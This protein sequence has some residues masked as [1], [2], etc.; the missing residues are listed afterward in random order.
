MKVR[1][2]HLINDKGEKLVVETREFNISQRNGD[3]KYEGYHIDLDW[4]FANGYMTLEEM[5]RRIE[6]P[7]FDDGKDSES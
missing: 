3:R 6:G 5:R 1:Q 4:Y 2:T 7:L